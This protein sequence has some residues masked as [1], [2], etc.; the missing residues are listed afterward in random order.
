MDSNTLYSSLSL[1]CNQTLKNR[2]VKSAMTEGLSVNGDINDRLITLYRTWAKGGAGLLISGNVMVD[3][4]HLERPGNIILDD[5][6]NTASLKTLVEQ[7][8]V[9]DGKIILQLSHPGRQCTR[10]VNSEPV[11]P[12]AVPLDLL[13]MFKAPRPLEPDEIHAIINRFAAAAEIA[14]ECGCDGVQIHGAHGYLIS[15]FL[16]PLSNVRKD[17]WGGSIE[18]RCRFLFEIISAIKKRVSENFMVGLK[19]NSSDFQKGGYSIED[20]KQVV[21]LLNPFPLDFIELS[22]GTYEQPQLLG[23]HGDLSSADLP[24]RQS[25]LLREAYFVNYA[26]QIRSISKHP[27][28]VTGGFEHPAAMEAALEDVQ[29]IGVARPFC[30]MPDWPNRLKEGHLQ[31]LPRYESKIVGTGKCGPSS[32]YKAIQA[33]NIQGEVS[34]FYYQILRLSEDKPVKTK[35]KLF[36]TLCF[37]IIREQWLARKRQK[38]L[39]QESR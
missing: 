12:S 23:H 27:I 13:S 21:S 30:V 28:M 32:P 29:L 7:V 20:C 35:K 5:R 11:A 15:Q 6:S 26:S 36:S 34:W 18:N 2:I 24:K 39:K 8:H 1:H 38:L 25:T 16:S 37:H 22:G 4:N 10:W 9:N 17:E 33:I 14:E 3:R 31:T 19:L